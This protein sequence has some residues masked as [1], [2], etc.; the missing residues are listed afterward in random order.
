MTGRLRGTE[1]SLVFLHGTRLSGSAWA[2]QRLLLEDRFRVVT[3]DLPGHGERAGEPFTLER[4]SAVVEAVL[5]AEQ[6]ATGR[7]PFLIGLSL[8]GFVAMDVAAR[9][10]DL[11][12]GLVLAGASAEPT[13]I[14]A[15]PIRVLEL[16]LDHIPEAFQIQANAR[17]FRWRYPATIA[18]PLIEGG[19][20]PSGGAAALRALRD[21]R[22]IPR[23]AAYPGPTLILN[24]AWDP[25]F[26]LGAPAFAAAARDVQ[27]VRLANASHLS[28]LDQPGAFATV[29][30][31]FVDALV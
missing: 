10:P 2:P 28:N 8:G 13:G 7:S 15:L 25:F 29:V 4:A 17:Y 14:L 19:F 20:W 18:T 1:P 22:F 30:E 9:R 23:L 12:G 27:R 21:E 6:A 24:G 31:R 11:V 16:L 3:P 5:A 26:R